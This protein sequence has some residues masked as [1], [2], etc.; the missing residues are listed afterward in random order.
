MEWDP[1]ARY[2]DARELQLALIACTQKNVHIESLL[3]DFLDGSVD[4]APPTKSAAKRTRRRASDAPHVGPML[5]AS[6]SPTNDDA[7]PDTP[8]AERGS[9]PMAAPEGTSTK[10]YGGEADG[11]LID[12]LASQND[13]SAAAPRDTE[14]SIPITPSERSSRKRSAHSEQT[15]RVGKAGENDDPVT[16]RGGELAKGRE[17]DPRK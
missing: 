17:K 15:V 7:A 10:K 5:A 14:R 1:N 2:Q 9:I 8:R 11:P 4:A 6:A 12:Y 16:R 13:S 3:S